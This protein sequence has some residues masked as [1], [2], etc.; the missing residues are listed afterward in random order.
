LDRSSKNLS[1]FQDRLK[2]VYSH[3]LTYWIGGAAIILLICSVTRHLWFKSTGFDLGIYDQV[4][5]LMSQGLPPISSYLGFHHMGNHAAYSVYPLALLYKIYPSVYWLLIVQA[6]CLAMG[7]LPT[8]MLARQAGLSHSLASAM[9]GVYLL[10]PL[11][12]NLNMFDFH[13]EVMALPV[14]LWAIWTARAGKPILF[15]IAIVFALGC[16]DALSLTIA[17]MGVWLLIFEKRRFYGTFALVVGFSW[18][19]LVTQWLIPTLSGQG[20]AALGRYAALG[21]DSVTEVALNLLRKPGIVLSLIFRYQTFRYL[22]ML[23]VPVLWGLSPRHMTPLISAIPVVLLNI[24]SKNEGQ[25]DLVHQYSLPV[26]PFLLVSVINTLAAGGGLLRQRRWILLWS[27]IGFIWLGK[28][29]WYTQEYKESIAT[30]EANREAIALIPKNQGVVITDNYLSPH[31][32]HRVSIHLV[33]PRTL[34]EDLDRADF[35]LLN[36]DHTQNKKE[37]DKVEQMFQQA[38]ADPRF[39]LSYERDQVYLF[40]RKE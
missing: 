11:I 33:R 29:S 19:L 14:M 35:I 16:K 37:R 36:L 2:P 5:Y 9:A 20:P 10:Y 13:P 34:A 18:F 3:F 15:M 12:F 8:W 4:V 1:S 40:A 7:A 31:L 30:W 28:Y 23:V 26:L 32:S 24:L 6:I 25:R 39:Q 17:A 27:L 21:G 22:V 38:K